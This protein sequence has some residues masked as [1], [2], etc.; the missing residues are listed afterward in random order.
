MAPLKVFLIISTLLP[1]LTLAVPVEYEGPGPGPGGGPGGSE[2]SGEWDEINVTLGLA[3][4]TGPIRID[5]SPSGKT[6]VLG[7]VNGV[8]E[9]IYENEK[10]SLG[11]SHDDAGVTVCNDNLLAVGQAIVSN[12]VNIYTRN[13]NNVWSLNQTINGP[14]SGSEFGRFISCHDDTLLVGAIRE[15]SNAGRAY[16]YQND[17]F[18]T[19]FQLMKTIDP[20]SSAGGFFGVGVVTDGEILAIADLLA[21]D[22]QIN[23]GSVH[24][25]EGRESNWSAPPNQI[26]SP[27]PQQNGRFGTDGLDKLGIVDNTIVATEEGLKIPYAFEKNE[28]GHY[29]PTALNFTGAASTII[30]GSG[31][32]TR[33]LVMDKVALTIQVFEH[34]APFTWSLFED[35]TRPVIIGGPGAPAPAE[36]S[37]GVISETNVYVI[38]E[39]GEYENVEYPLFEYQF[40]NETEYEYEYEY[41]YEDEEEDDDNST[42]R[43]LLGAAVFIPFILAFGL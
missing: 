14:V 35:L 32:G 31:S 3:S 28:S 19:P 33:V 5:S 10:T 12:L 27:T 8:L 43:V 38:I 40:P 22:G 6:L 39:T 23:A 26:Q 9:V 29:Q 11:S 30:S 34:T 42:D 1:V 15:A 36:N 17:G 25:Y 41:E 7:Q 20:P 24:I 13:D 2:V 4:Q 16:V 18:G 37:V 21:V